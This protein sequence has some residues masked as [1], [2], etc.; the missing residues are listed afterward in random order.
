MSAHGSPAA[1]ESPVAATTVT[2][3]VGVGAERVVQLFQLRVRNAV[4]PTDLACGAERDDAALRGAHPQGSD[5][6]RDRLVGAVQRVSL[7][8]E[9]GERGAG[10]DRV[11]QLR[12]QD[13][14]SIRQPWRLWPS[15]GTREP[16]VRRR[17]VEET[18]EDGEV[19]AQVG[20]VRWRELRLGQLGQHDGFA[21]AVD[22]AA[23]GAAG[24]RRR[25]GAGAA[26]SRWPLKC[27]WPLHS[28]TLLVLRPRW[29]R[30][31]PRV[32]RR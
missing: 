30:R 19:L 12:V 32:R 21:A 29:T 6:G 16:Q 24:R 28:R 10:S 1:P 2:W 7:D 18:I 27:S 3:C 14:L 11:D 20:D 8:Q 26:C 9:D 13:L 4:L 5:R 25:P 23:G 17:Q 31:R 15:E 22:S